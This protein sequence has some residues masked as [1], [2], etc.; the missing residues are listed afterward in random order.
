MDDDTAYPRE[1][2]ATDLVV[3]QHVPLPDTA[4]PREG[5]ATGSSR[6]K[7]SSLEIQLI[8]ARGRLPHNGA[9]II[10]SNIDTA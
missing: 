10:N 9:K 3:C 4:Y 7:P 2:T 6:R 1:G 5:T 8:P